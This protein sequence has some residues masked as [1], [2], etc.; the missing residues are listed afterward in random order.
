MLIIRQDLL[1]I[2]NLN[3][4]CLDLS[5][6]IFTLLLLQFL[7]LFFKELV[8][9]LKL[10]LFVLNLHLKQPVLS[11][12]PLVLLVKGLLSHHQLLLGFPFLLT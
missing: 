11:T 3:L 2:L 6:V 7:L 4:S 9:I 8:R 5:Y 10:A 12:A 1:A